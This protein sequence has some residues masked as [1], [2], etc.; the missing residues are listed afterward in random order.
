MVVDQPREYKSERKVLHHTCIY[1]K[2][3]LCTSRITTIHTQNPFHQGINAMFTFIVPVNIN[4]V[5]FRSDEDIGLCVD[6]KHVVLLD[7]L[8]LH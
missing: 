6:L 8:I 4:K 5:S 1:H 3:R 7:K 2:Q